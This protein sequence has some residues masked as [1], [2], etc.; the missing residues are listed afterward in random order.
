MVGL[1]MA[2]RTFQSKFAELAAACDGVG[3]YILLKTV[4]HA[5]SDASGQE[6]ASRDS[7]AGDI[8]RAYCAGATE[9][10]FEAL[11]ALLRSW[12]ARWSSE[13]G[14]VQ[15]MLPPLLQLSAAP[16]RVAAALDRASQT[17]KHQKRLVEVLRELFQRLHRDRDRREGALVVCCELLRLYF[18]LGQAS[19]CSFLLAAV[20]CQQRPL[21]PTHLPMAL[22]LPLW[23]LW[24]KHSVLEGN[25]LD[26]EERLAWAL[27]RCP[28]TARGNRRRILTY[29][30]P[31]RLR[32]GRFPRKELLR[33]CRLQSF[34]GI[35]ASVAKGNVQRFNCEL[36]A[37]EAEFIQSGTYLV[38]EKLKLLA[39]RNLCRCVYDVVARDIEAAGK[40]DHRH[41]QD[42]APYEWAFQWQD[43]CDADETM[44]ILANLIY[45]GAIRGYMS[46]EHR[47]IV[48]SK[49]AAFPP[50]SAWGAKA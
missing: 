42:L 36:R 20:N 21:D 32:L 47:K 25:V 10:G 48:F 11:C 13:K 44:C 31:C 5:G 2:A 17:D 34:A 40:A 28:P 43:G 23:F 27:A 45:L 3:L 37:H 41:K 22:A 9:E 35:A 15:W 19:Q 18:R 50:P 26:A 8:E 39:Y 14:N 38:V 12:C 16:R 24:G 49:D 6:G 33:D 1:R 29:L 46:D 4:G 30:V 7:K